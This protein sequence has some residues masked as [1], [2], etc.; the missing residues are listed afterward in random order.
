MWNDSF[1]V[2]TEAYQLTIEI[3]NRHL[4]HNNGRFIDRLI[5]I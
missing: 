1:A 3:I 5:T 2:L 4:Y